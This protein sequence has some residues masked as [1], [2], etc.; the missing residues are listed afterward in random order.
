MTR[1]AAGFTCWPVDWFSVLCAETTC[2]VIWL[3]SCMHVR[4]LVK[5]H[6]A[7]STTRSVETNE[8]SVWCGG[9]GQL[10]LSCMIASLSSRSWIYLY[11]AR[12][13]MHIHASHGSKRGHGYPDTRKSVWKSW[14]SWSELWV[15]ARISSTTS[16]SI[17]TDKY[18][19]KL[20]M[21]TCN[22]CPLWQ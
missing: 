17:A 11:L 13:H 21:C 8:T 6:F 3:F 12:C 19:I 22:T 14:Y 10:I 7:L 16:S 1:I 4:G 5:E 9:A 18:C 2:P 20:V 15:T